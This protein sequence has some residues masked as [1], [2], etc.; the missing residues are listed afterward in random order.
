MYKRPWI[1]AAV[2]AGLAGAVAW[3]CGPMFPNQL[4]DQRA[5]TLKSA[6]QNSFAFEAARLLP[7]T[8]KLESNEPAPYGDDKK[9]DEAQAS[10]LDVTVAQLARIKTLRELPTGDEAFEQG[11]DLPADLRAYVAGALDFSRDQQDKAAARFEQ[12]LALPPEQARLR[13]VWAAYMLGRIHAA[14]ANDAAADAAVFQRERA[15]AAKAFQLAR[16][17]AVDGASDTQGLAVSSFGEEARL[18]L[19]DHGTQCSWGDLYGVATEAVDGADADGEHE[20]D[21]QAPAKGAGCGRGLAADDLKRAITLYAAQAGH[22]SDSAVNSLVAVA[23]FSM[24]Q[25]QL[26]DQLIDSPVAQR[27]LV[28]YALARMGGEPDDTAANAA[29]P[30]VD[31]R[32]TALV[33]AI[34]KRGLDHVAGADR[35]A[36]LAYS[37]GNYDLAATLAGES[38]GPLA[39][40]V[41]AKLALQK[42]DMAAANAAYAAAAK[43]FPKADDPQAALEPGNVHLIL[44]EQGVLALAR[45]EYVEAMGHLYDAASAVGGD[46]NEYEDEGDGVGMGYGNDAAYVAERVLTVDELKRFVDARAPESLNPKDKPADGYY[47]SLPLADNLRWLLARRLMRAG[48]YDE[49]FAYF[50]KD[51]DPRIAMQDDNGKPQPANLRSKARAY[52]QAMHDGQ[53]AWTDIGKAQALYAAAV[54]ARENGMEI[55]GYEQSPDFQDNG[56]SFQGGSG[57]APE[58]LKQAYVTDGERQ[59]YADSVARPDYRFHYRYIAADEASRAADLLPPR[60]QAFAAVLCQATGW[61][62]EGPPD[63]EDHYQYYGDP[64]PDQPSERE[65]HAAALYQRYVKQGPYVAWAADFGRDCEEPDFDGARA[66]KRSA[67]VRAVKHAVRDYFP[68]ELGAFVLVVAGFAGWLARRRR[69]KT[70]V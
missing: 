42:G 28:A 64:K 19:Y 40:W 2:V 27:L 56:G 20:K 17:R 48:R 15:V 36:S 13:S 60:S 41:R 45:G 37:L 50:P 47:R 7:A 35:L 66:L 23:D 43:A 14:K 55:L 65:R 63:Y 9:G 12:V 39:D 29:K 24:R 16:T 38:S 33:Q 67:Q 61:M 32:L 3:A 8:D 1:V 31:P 11:K 30:K 34:K 21:S 53:H 46:G 4:L 68:Y 44:G 57:Q 6:P 52:A 51:D 58:S 5:A 54:I 25:P 18:Y 59:R 62:L 69:R 70:A 49:A 26:L 22:Q 10:S